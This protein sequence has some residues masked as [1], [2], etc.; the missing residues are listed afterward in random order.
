MRARFPVTSLIA[1]ALALGALS[2]Q[3]APRWSRVG[4]AAI[5]LGLT[6]AAGG[7]VTET[8]F[9]PDGAVLYV[10]TAAG[11]VWHTSDDGASWTPFAVELD[12]ADPFSRPPVFD[13][14]AASPDDDPAALVIQHPF[15]GSER[16][17]LGFNLYRSTDGGETWVNLTGDALGSI[18]GP[19]QSSVA[20]SPIAPDTLVVG[21]S[22]GVWKSADN[23]L[24]WVGLNRNL[25]NFPDGRLLH[26]PASDRFLGLYADG[27]GELETTG[28]DGAT[29][30]EAPPGSESFA[31]ARSARLPAEDRLRTAPFPL[32][33]PDGLVVSHRVWMAGIPV[34]G[35]LTACG[36]QGCSHPARHYISTFAS[37]GDRA[38]LYLGTSDGRLWTS[39]NSGLTWRGSAVGLPQSG[40]V[41]ALF[42]HPERSGSA[43]VVFDG[44]SG[45][46]IFRTTNGGAFW[47]DL[48]AD[49][50]G[51][52]LFALAADGATGAVYVAG[53]AGV[54][55]TMADLASPGPATAWQSAGEL[56]AGAS[57]VL[58][59]SVTGRLYALV[60]GYGVYTVRAPAV[61]DALRVL[62]AADLTERAAAPGGLLSILGEGL[63]RAGVEDVAAPVLFSDGTETQ[64][65]V[66]Y[67]VKGD[68]L[69]LQLTT[70]SGTREVGFPLAGVS[71]AIFVDQGNP[72]VLDAGTGRLLNAT[73]PAVAGGRILIL[74]N[75][76]GAVKPEWPTGVPAPGEAPPQTVE[77]VKVYLNGISLRVFSSTLAPGYIG[78][79]LVE[80]EM[81]AVLMSG[82]G[83]LTLEAAA[84]TSNR[85]RIYTEP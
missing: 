19:G 76:L 77:A 71:P 37:G 83:E 58:L 36:T 51:G 81:P 29:W 84:V 18:I 4:S 68:A 40:A 70:G 50:P 23:G 41:T 67:G 62:N 43:L 79:Y 85:V 38:T 25:P 78:T 57:D 54:F 73:Y 63:E 49:L 55:Y 72:L 75:G 42:A 27:F 80:A 31:S 32:A 59:N 34:T 2:A 8:A 20:F 26:P 13:P 39:E 14:A 46:R 53:E 22:L 16:F 66:P 21:N 64:I 15:R 74:G 30:R 6:G 5:D 17:A 1:A 82:T 12:S 61:S 52:R 10:R 7:P 45:G 33:T 60:A 24:T 47:D 44:E 9:S 65:Q 28:L 35:D 48:T 69:S 11:R 56:P 3:A